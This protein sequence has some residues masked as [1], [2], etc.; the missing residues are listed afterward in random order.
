MTHNAYEAVVGQG[1][2][3]K[4]ASR[5]FF[6]PYSTLHD[7]INGNTKLET[8]RSGPDPLLSQEE[9]QTL[10]THIELMSSL[11]MDTPALKLQYF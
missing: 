9:E 8:T 6:V 10:V 3:I 4:T 2:S 5:P 11:A 7:R 1:I